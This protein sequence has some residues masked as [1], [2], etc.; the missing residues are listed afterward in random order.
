MR[1]YKGF[2]DYYTNSPYANNM[3]VSNQTQSAIQAKPTTTVYEKSELS[4]ELYSDK[5]MNANDLSAFILDKQS[6]FNASKPFFADD[7]EVA[8]KNKAFMQELGFHL[9]NSNQGRLIQDDDGSYWVQD[10]LGNYAKVDEGFFKKIGRGIKD[11]AG[12]V[13]LGTLGAIGGGLIGGPVGMVGGG[14]LGA[15]IGAGGDYYLNTE[16]TNQDRNLQEALML[17]G[18][19]AGLSLVG[20]A[21]LGGVAKGANA[22]KGA[23]KGIS[24]TANKASEIYDGVRVGGENLKENI[25]DKFRNAMPN[26]IND[27]ASGGVDTARQRAKEIINSKDINAYEQALK[28]SYLN[29]LEVS[30]ENAI[31]KKSSD[32]VRKYGDNSKYQVVKNTAQKISDTLDFISKN[33]GSKQATQVQQELLNM[34][35]MDK[36]LAK[37]LGQVLRE[38]P[39]LANTLFNQLAKQDEAILKEL[40]LEKDIKAQNLYDMYDARK[41]RA[42]DEFGTSLDKIDKLNP[43]GIKIDTMALN[44][45]ADN[46]GIYSEATPTIIKD[47][48][49]R[50]NNGELNGKS[51]KEINDEISAINDKLKG[52]KSYNYKEFLNSVKDELLN[53]MV[54]NSNNP[55]LA[56]EI[57]TKARSDYAK[58]KTYEK[59]KIGKKLDGDEAK[60]SKNLNEIINNTNKNKNYEAITKGL[61]ETEIAELDNQIIKRTIDKHIVEI[62]GKKVVDYAKVVEAMKNYNPK[63]QSGQLKKEVLMAMGRLRKDIDI[64]IDSIAE[65]KIPKNGSNFATTFDGKVKAMFINSITDYIAFYFGKLFGLSGNPGL[66]IQF[67]RMVNNINTLQDFKTQTKAFIDGIKDKHIKAQAKKAQAEFNEKTKDL[68]KGNGF[69][70]DKPD[71]SKNELKFVGKNGKEYTIDKAVRNEWMKTFNLKSIDDDYIPKL[72]NEIKTALNGKDIKL[73]KGS[74]LKLIEKDRIKYIPHIK[75]TLENPQAIIKDKNDYIFVKNI[76]NQTYF[77]SIG[78]DYETHLTIVSNSPKKQNNIINKF[79]NAEVIYSSTARALPTSRASSETKQVPFSSENSTQ[80]KPK[81]NLIQRLDDDIK[82]REEAKKNKKSVK[83]RLDEDIKAREK[84]SDEFFKRFDE[85]LGKNKN[86]KLDYLDDMELNSFEY[87]ISRKF[88]ID[89]KESIDKGI[90]KDIP[91]PMRDRIEEKLNIKPLKEFGTNYAE[92]YHDGTR[93]IKKLM[94]EKQG[95]VAGAFHRKDLGDIDLVWGEVT[96][97]IKHKGYGLAHIIDKHPDLDLEQ[98]PKIIKNGRLIKDDKGRAR[99]QFDNKVIGIKDNWKGDKTNIWIVTSYELQ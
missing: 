35:M 34:A 58:F 22:F 20:D 66:R 97:K 82:A 45:I 46:A 96:D 77:T 39:E 14:A 48:F 19:N 72:P 32:L 42:Y 60:I 26:L 29:P 12:S 92:Y 17:M 33:T 30:Q 80:E 67:R 75:E 84:E 53:S 31:F 52:E 4:D 15:G 83:E 27:Y 61:N 13:A 40:S 18:E 6:R 70:M 7:N 51:A 25:G 55:K 73:T 11:N 41:T 99:I 65:A 94:L 8:L 85:F 79:K 56:N 2:E 88:I 90:K 64:I 44:E 21:V 91:S 69:F 1:I 86:Y 63:S 78:K 87:D 62:D 76:N 95:Q 28:D 50:A 98:I 93:A 71:I 37:T 47:F 59:S 9:K 57:L 36:D 5:T 38:K 89:A 68:I 43:N 16:L 81:K 10:N 49:K 23:Y 54:K 24:N 74:L 3:Q